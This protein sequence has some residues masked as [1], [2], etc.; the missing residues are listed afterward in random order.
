MLSPRILVCCILCL[1]Q[2]CQIVSSN[3]CDNR[4]Q[5]SKFGKCCS[6]CPPGTY[7]SSECTDAK[8]SDCQP[9]GP[10]YYQSE[11]NKLDHCQMH[12]SCNNNGG[13]EVE[14]P[15]TSTSDTI[16]RCQ[17]G[18][19]CINK[20][21]EICKDNEVCEPGSGVIYKEDGGFARQVCVKCEA[22]YFSNVSSDLEPC[23]KWSNCGL[24]QMLENGTTTK[25]VKCGTPEPSSKVGL[26]LVIVLLSAVLAV[27]ILSFFIYCGC[28][29]ENRMKI[30][31][32]INRLRKN[33]IQKPIQEREMTE[34]GRILTTAGNEDKSPED[35]TELLSV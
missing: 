27:T 19:Y 12:K 10:D 8:D 20:D 14:K 17:V 18:K 28:N 25:D 23:R 33:K 9:C 29:Q 26:V 2:C 21:C 1:F 35:G 5:Y 31:D 22:G 4:S 24:L 13:F 3:T 34:N 11:W 30:R 32:I 6:K 16:C 7:T 15:G